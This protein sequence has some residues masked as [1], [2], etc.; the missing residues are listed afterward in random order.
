VSLDEDDSN[1]DDLHRYKEIL[2]S[3]G[4]FAKYSLDY[5]LPMLAKLLNEKYLNLI[6]LLKQ[7][8]ISKQQGIDTKPMTIHLTSLSEDLHW[9]MLIIGFLI[10]EINSDQ[11][12]IPDHIM[13]YSIKYS[14][15]IDLN[16]I[17]NLL[18]SLNQFV[19]T[20][21]LSRQTI[22]SNLI[23]LRMT[24]KFDP[25]ISVFINSFQLSEL[26]IHMFAL[27]MLEYLSPQVASTL[28][29]FLT[30]MTE[31]YLYMNEQIYNEI[32]PS[33]HIV[34]GQDTECSKIIL[35]Y[36]L[37]K[38]INNFYIWSSESIVT[39]QTAKLLYEIVK[40]RNMVKLILQ[41]EQFW[42]ISKIAVVN[43]MP[44]VLLPSSV[45]KT[46]IKCLISSCDAQNNLMQMHFFNTILTPL[47][48]RFEKL[49]VLKPEQI[50]SENTIKEVMSLIETFNG[51]VEGTSK[52]ILK[53]I[54]PFAL[55]R[56]E[57]GVNLL[58]AYH[59]YGEIVELVLHMFNNVIEKFLFNLTDW[60][61][62]VNQ[63]YHCFLCLIQVF[64][65][66]NSSNT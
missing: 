4:E 53:D 57:Q 17:P 3:I 21:H 25:I 43:E 62:V 51:I 65:R 10:F 44:W 34:F 29:W 20:T 56:L 40:K 60:P 37:R 46:I 22:C 30:Q 11:A 61:D 41:N 45:K 27:N 1:E 55:P 15:Y 16:Q 2:Y 47:A 19:S 14:N 5:S 12:K 38:L 66:H 64:T 42:Q 35:N 9:L 54:V 28:I 49:R 59:N 33:L 48:E 13:K 7:I 32:S 36:L 58:D 8:S 39:I 23:D 6:E 52:S 50:H 18:A 26:E 63:I 24:E 31:S